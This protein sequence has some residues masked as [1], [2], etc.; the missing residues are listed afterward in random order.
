M[1]QPS[2]LKVGVIFITLLLVLYAAFQ[3]YLEESVPAAV[4]SEDIFSYES[5]ESICLESVISE[6]NWLK[7]SS[8]SENDGFFAPSLSDFKS[9]P[10]VVSV[11]RDEVTG[12]V[13]SM[14]D[15]TSAFFEEPG[16]SEEM[17]GFLS[18]VS[19]RPE[20]PDFSSREES[21]APESDLSRPVSSN[22]ASNQ[23]EGSKPVTSS[24][25]ASSQDLA[26]LEAEIARMVGELERKYA[27]SILL[28]REE[29]AWTGG[30][31]A[32][33]AGTP[34]ILKKGLAEL[35]RALVV[36]PDGFFENQATFALT[37]RLTSGGM[38]FPEENICLL[39]CS[40]SFAVP[41]RSTLISN[42]A[43]RFAEECD[44]DLTAYNPEDFQYGI[45]ERRYLYS[46]INRENG[47]F[48]SMTAQ[49]S[50]REEIV[51]LFDAI[52]TKGNALIG[53][54][55]DSPLRSK[56]AAC[57]VSAVSWRSVLSQNRVI[58]AFT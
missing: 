50:M 36:F 6:E 17:G 51:E 42:A 33:Y 39:S 31:V 11:P 3:M 19:S 20:F 7:A 18:E 43:V 40:E 8:T 49:N 9:T 4:Y 15:K 46:S 57:C 38:A 28:L 24:E 34:D 35:S 54:H 5:Q 2:G 45:S 29:S 21:V 41:L 27:I 52:L 58:Q 10:P 23:P 12:S 16:F 22:V 55:P 56:I 30:G 37:K 14:E 25:P 26:A 53:I 48:L 47:Y 32:E 1:Q 13:S 44:L